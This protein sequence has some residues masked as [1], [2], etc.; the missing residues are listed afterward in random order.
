MP[1]PHALIVRLPSGT[2]YWYA[3]EVP[4]VGEIVSHFGTRYLVLSAEPS[5][6]ERIVITLAAEV[7]ITADPVASS[8]LA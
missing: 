3:E 1:A 2:E 4:E 5:E 6:N 7:D 8:P